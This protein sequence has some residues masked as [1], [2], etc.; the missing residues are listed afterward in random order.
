MSENLELSLSRDFPVSADKLYR[1]WTEPELLVQWFAPPPWKTL[2]AD[3]DV[4]PGG[5]SLVV[6][7]GPDGPEVPNAGVYLEVVPNRRLVMTDAYTRAWVPSAKP[8]VTIILDFLDL[9]NGSSRYTATV[10]H[11]TLED[12]QAH[13][14]MGFEQGWGTAAA[15]M[16]AMAATLG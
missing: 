14:N 12:R 16:G 3:L 5:A 8:F 7:Q 6:M 13:E 9:G 11:W 4:R 1:C 2:R 10:R 15:Q